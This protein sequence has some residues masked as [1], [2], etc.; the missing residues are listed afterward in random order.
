VD[1]D[2]TRR[3]SIRDISEIKNHL[4]GLHQS[5]MRG[6]LGVHLMMMI[7]HT[8]FGFNARLSFQSE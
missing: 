1:D 5:G 7:P 6:Y 2:N 8:S 4:N 3:V